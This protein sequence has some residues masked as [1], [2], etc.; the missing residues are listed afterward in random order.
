MDRNLLRLYAAL[1]VASYSDIARIDEE[2]AQLEEDVA[3]LAGRLAVLRAR[4]EAS[5]RAEPS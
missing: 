2:V 4:L 3:R 5:P 1:N